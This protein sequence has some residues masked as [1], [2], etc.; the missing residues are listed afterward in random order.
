MEE[1]GG[2]GGERE[3]GGGRREEGGGRREEGGGRREEGGG[4]RGRG[5]EKERRCGY[6]IGEYIMMSLTFNAPAALSQYSN[7]GLTARLTGILV[8]SQITGEDKSAKV[9]LDWEDM[10]VCVC[11]Y[12][13]CEDAIQ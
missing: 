6:L 2:G 9:N 3:E 7:I 5:E 11:T 10:C 12:V 13:L 4:R 1:G 8:P